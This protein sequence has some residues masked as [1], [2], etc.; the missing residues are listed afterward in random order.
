MVRIPR[1][2]S[3]RTVSA[4]R[5]AVDVR[6]PDSPAKPQFSG[7]YRAT[8]GYGQQIADRSIEPRKKTELMTASCND[9]N[10]PKLA[11]AERD[12]TSSD[13]SD[14]TGSIRT[15]PSRGR[16]RP[17]LEQQVLDLTQRQR[18]RNSVGH[19]MIWDA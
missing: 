5:E 14:R 2:Y 15:V 3:I 9:K 4:Q 8:M 11:L 6:E 7:S 17:T 13:F 1:K 12:C 18:I 16:C 19:Q 10:Q